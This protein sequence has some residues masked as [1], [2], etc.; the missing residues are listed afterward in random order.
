MTTSCKDLNGLGRVFYIFMD[1]PGPLQ[2]DEVMLTGP[3]QG[4]LR[5]AIAVH[6]IPSTAIEES[7]AG[8]IDAL[9]C[10]TTFMVHHHAIFLISTVFA[11]LGCR[12]KQISL[13]GHRAESFADAWLQASD[14]STRL[15]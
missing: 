12:Y 7:T 5:G 8:C 1:V 3:M 4:K 15:S 2:L 9:A 10:F 13:A 6:V 14:A 11:K